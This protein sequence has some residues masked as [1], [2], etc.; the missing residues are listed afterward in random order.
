MRGLRY[1]YKG[2]ISISIQGIYKG[3]ITYPRNKKFP[4]KFFAPEMHGLGFNIREYYKG[5]I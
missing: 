1:Q 5:D 3:Y 4:K 2:C